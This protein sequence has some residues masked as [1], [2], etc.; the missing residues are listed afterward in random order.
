ML[1]LKFDLYLNKMYNDCSFD[2]T[3]NMSLM[4]QITMMA[5]R[6]PERFKELKDFVDELRKSGD[7][8][9]LL[10]VLA[11]CRYS[12]RSFEEGMSFVSTLLELRPTDIEA[13][14]DF[15]FFLSHMPDG[16]DAHLN[17]RFHLPHFIHNYLKY[18]FRTIN[19]KS[20]VILDSLIRNLS[21][22]PEIR[23]G[24]DKKVSF[25]EEYL[26]L[27]GACNNN[28]ET[29]PTP[30]RLRGYDFEDRLTKIGLISLSKYLF[31]KARKKSLKRFILKGGEPTLHP[32]YLKI[33]RILAAA[34]KDIAIHVRTNAR[35]FCNEKFLIQHR[36]ASGYKAIFEVS[37]LSDNQ[38]AHDA[39]TRARGSHEQTLRGIDNILS[40]GMKASARVTLC[41]K[42][43]EELPRILDFLLEKYSKEEGFTEI[44][45]LLPPPSGESLEIY[46][47]DAVRRFRTA[48]ENAISARKPEKCPIS[49][50]NAILAE[51]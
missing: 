7:S 6:E 14:L 50:K 46:Y 10:A 32:N 9:Q 23:H 40:A 30:F 21:R 35:I 47:P 13:W 4:T 24:Y 17:L 20:A 27:N 16:Y 1:S 2:M 31:L 41:D 26:I 15:C 43:I 22:A 19:S 34:R 8:D 25:D 28:C 33:V 51:V 42:N 18:D 37:V 12:D 45:V 48:A 38:D 36:D 44:S 11:Y 39:M 3:N 49:L 5:F 29:C